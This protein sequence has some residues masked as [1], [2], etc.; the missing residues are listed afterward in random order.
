MQGRV[1]GIAAVAVPVF[2]HHTG[3]A[4]VLSVSGPSAR[5]SER[6]LKEIAPT[7]QKYAGELSELLGFQQS[8][9][10]PREG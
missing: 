1:A 4:A 9:F 5:L 2:A 10:Q 7:A 8:P 6:R 3:I